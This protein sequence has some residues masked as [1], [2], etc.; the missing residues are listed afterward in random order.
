MGARI[1]PRR[2]RRTYL[3]EWREKKGL[4]QQQLA[5]RLGVSD[6]TVHRWEKGIAKLSTPVMEAIAE[7][8]DIEPGDLY[9][10]PAR[11]TQDDLLRDLPPETVQEAI[12]FI[13]YLKK[14][15]G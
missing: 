2:P 4:T 12:R 3:K 14:R 1:G 9:R 10:D 5:D 15:A 7:A 8:L 11:P 6:V 13:D